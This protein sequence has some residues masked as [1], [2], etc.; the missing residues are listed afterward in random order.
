MELSGK[1]QDPAAVPPESL[2]WNLGDKKTLLPQPGIEPPIAGSSDLWLSH[3]TTCVIM[4]GEDLACSY[5]IWP[6]SYAP[7]TTQTYLWEVN[8]SFG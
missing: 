1:V 7:L 3:Y 2:V 6:D 5:A 8:G 4:N